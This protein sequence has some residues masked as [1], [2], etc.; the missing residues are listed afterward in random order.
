MF[1]NYKNKAQ[2]EKQLKNHPIFKDKKIR[3]Q[4]ELK[5]LFHATLGLYKSV[6]EEELCDELESYEE[7]D[8]CDDSRDETGTQED[9]FKKKSEEKNACHNEE[10]IDQEEHEEEVTEETSVDVA[11]EYAALFLV[12]RLYKIFEHVLLRTY[13]LENNLFDIHAVHDIDFEKVILFLKKNKILVT[14]E[15]ESAIYFLQ[16]LVN[17][18]EE[19][20]LFKP[21]GAFEDSLLSDD[22]YLF[23][24]VDQGTIYQTVANLSRIMERL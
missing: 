19:K 3:S 14:D 11:T 20:F 10:D 21:S 15:E 16:L 2:D 5:E 24:D 7:G 12:I 6:I 22:D 17:A 18:T 13:I 23:C 8:I 4:Q 1:T 9:C